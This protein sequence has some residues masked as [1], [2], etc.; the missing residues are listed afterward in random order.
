ME[1]DF[2]G[3]GW[4]MFEEVKVNPCLKNQENL[5]FVWADATLLPALVEGTVVP[6]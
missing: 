1:Q 3:V 4:F 2:A 6:K 5:P